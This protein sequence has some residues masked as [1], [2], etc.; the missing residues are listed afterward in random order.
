MIASIWSFALGC[1]TFLWGVA[2][3]YAPIRLTAKANG[4]FVADPS[5][6]IV[7]IVPVAIMTLVAG[8]LT[9][10]ASKT[11]A[12]ASPGNKSISRGLGFS[13]LALCLIGLAI[14]LFI[15]YFSYFAYL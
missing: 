10:Y 4:G 8:Y 13:G 3:L 12:K 7:A 1:V 11:A 5:R 6:A 15:S 2:S 14:A 9:W